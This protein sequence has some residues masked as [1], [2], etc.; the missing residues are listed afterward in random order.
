MTNAPIMPWA[1]RTVGT[2]H[3]SPEDLMA[4]ANPLNP[5]IHPDYQAEAVEGL[6][7]QVG[8][9]KRVIVNQTTGRVID[10][11]LRIK[12][13]LAK[14]APTIPVE[15]VELSEAEERLVLATLDP[16]AALAEFDA[17]TLTRLGEEVKLDFEDFDLSAFFK[18]DELAA[19]MGGEP[20]NAGE[21]SD[22]D[23]V[24]Y[25]SAYIVLIECASESEQLTMIGRLSKQGIEC[26]AIVS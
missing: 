1:D 24:G 16:T 2:G 22:A 3:M 13:A 8:F 26:K 11:H 10:G 18:D 5:R 15:Y 9:V 6:L 14:G 17:E 4:A 23:S 21:D 19:L 20:D 12:L 25:D 7:D